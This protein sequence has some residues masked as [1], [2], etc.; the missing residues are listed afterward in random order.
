[1]AI[2]GVEVVISVVTFTAVKWH[3]V[4]VHDPR[5]QQPTTTRVA[6]KSVEHHSTEL[7]AC[8]Y[9]TDLIDAV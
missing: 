1:M 8:I 7:L 9:V 4:V 5:R 2:P 6:S 3:L